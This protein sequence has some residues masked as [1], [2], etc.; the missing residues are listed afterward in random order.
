MGLKKLKSGKYK[1]DLRLRSG[2]GRVRRIAYTDKYASE[3]LLRNIMELDACKLAGEHPDRDLTAWL[4]RQDLALKEYLAEH[5]LIPESI[6]NRSK[7]LKQHLE[8]F[9][10]HKN[11]KSIRG[12]IGA[13]QVGL[14]N[15]RIGRMI[16]EC[17]FRSVEDISHSAVDTWIATKYESKALSA[18]SC[19]DY[20]QSLKQFCK[21][22]DVNNIIADNPIA[23]L[24]PIPLNS[25]N[26]SPRR[27][28]SENELT[29]LLA[30]V[31]KASDTVQGLNGE[32]RY[33]VYQ[34]ILQTG[35]RHNEVRTL[36]Y[37]D[38][39]F[40]NSTV[41]V[42]DVNA[43]NSRTDTL[44]FMEDL[45]AELQEYFRG[46]AIEGKVRAFSKMGTKGF[47]MIKADLAKVDIPYETDE[48]KAD[49]HALRHTFCTLLARNG[50]LPQVT[51]RLMRHSDI[52]LTMKSYTHL[53]VD[54]KRAAIGELPVLRKTPENKCGQEMSET[55]GAESDSAS[56]K[57]KMCPKSAQ[58]VPRTPD[59]LNINL[60]ADGQIAV[61][62]GSTQS[63]CFTG[64]NDKN[65]AKDSVF[66]SENEFANCDTNWWKRRESNPRPAISSERTSTC[67]VAILDLKQFSL[68]TILT[69][70]VWI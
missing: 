47:K 21:W 45:S 58:I 43:K 31:R 60:D 4:E 65:T 20:L 11:N 51:Q 3:K 53:H 25:E 27:A 48:G 22:L 57:S 69:A 63:T 40:E 2:G 1:I 12:G 14:L 50:V 15:N 41:T 33:L 18:K 54:D 62:C 24:T 35:L 55:D 46:N 28:L 34:L 52:N 26:T 49:F 19:N 10:L 39:D 32:E 68:A 64:S 66:D 13:K 56:G 61:M 16:K 70:P 44:P 36:L 29:K 30:T 9:I 17:K 7:T 5:G 6:V 59:S 23:R 8:D 67:V 42:R 37:G 38:F